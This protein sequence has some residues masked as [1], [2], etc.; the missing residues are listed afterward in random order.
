MRRYL[1]TITINGNNYDATP[2]ADSSSFSV[3]SP[4]CSQEKKS[5]NGTASVNIKG[6]ANPSFYRTFM[7][8]LLEAQQSKILGNCLV[9]IKD[10]VLN[11]IVH[12]GWLNNDELSI[13]SAFF[14]D[15]LN[16]A[17]RDKMRLLDTKIKINRIWENASRNQIVQDLLVAL[18]EQTGIT[19]SYLSTELSDSDIVGHYVVSEGKEKTYREVIDTLLFEAIGYVLWYDPDA[20][21]FRI[22]IIPT[23]YDPEQEYRVVTY[24]VENR[25]VTQSSVYDNDGILLTYPTIT[26]RPN[27]NVFNEG[28]NNQIDNE[29]N[30]KG[31]EI[32][33]GDYFPI[34]GDVKEIY[35]E[36]SVADRAYISGESRL[37]TEG[38]ELLYAKDVS[39][40]L[41]SNP[42]LSIADAIPSVNWYG[43]AEFY[44]DRARI[45]FRNNNTQKSNVTTFSLTGTAVYVSALN[46]I[47]VPS[48]CT[49]PEE[50][51]VETIT[52]NSKAKAFADWYYNSR[53]Y[54]C[55]TSRWSEP[56]GYS[57]LG[58]IVLV[59]H[60]D[61]GV[62]MPHVVV[63]ITDSC[64]GGKS[65][66]IRLKEIVA[67]S[68]YGWQSILS[69]TPPRV[70]TPSVQRVENAR[71][72]SGT[73]LIG[74][75]RVRGVAG[76]VGDYYLN[77]ETG[78]IYRCVES[79]TSQTAIWQW[80]MNNKGADA[81]ISG[82]KTQIEYG[83]STSPYS[84]VYPDGTLGYDS[85]NP[86]GAIDPDNDTEFDYG[87]KDVSGWTSDYDQWYRGLYVWMRVKTT[88]ADGNVT[89]N[90]PTYCAELT[91][92]LYDGSKFEIIPDSPTWDRNFADSGNTTVGFSFIGTGF[93]NNTVFAQSIKSVV[94]KAYRGSLLV[95]TYTL[96]YP[97]SLHIDYEFPTDSD[98]DRIDISATLEV[99][100]DEY[101]IQ[102]QYADCSMSAHDI[103]QYKVYGGVF[104]SE[105]LA[106]AWFNINCGGLIDGY[107][108]FDSTEKVVKV[109]RDGVWAVFDLIHDVNN[110]GQV[111]T[112]AERDLWNAYSTMTPEQ[113]DTAFLLYGYK[114][115]L[116]ARAIATAKLIMY[117]EG[118][119]VSENISTDPTEDIDD[120]FL[121]KNGYRFEG[122]QNGIV[123]ASGGYFNEGHFKGGTFKS[124]KVDGDSEFRGSVISDV[125]E[126]VLQTENATQCLASSPSSVSGQADGVLG[127]EIKTNLNA[128]L[129]NNLFDSHQQNDN[130]TNLDVWGVSN[131][132]LNGHSGASINK[133]LRFGSVSSALRP[134]NTQETAD[135]STDV[136]KSWTNPY[137]CNI[138]IRPNI[139][140][141]VRSYRIE[142]TTTS[143]TKTDDGSV[144]GAVVAPTQTP[145]PSNP[146]DGETWIDYST[147]TQRIVNGHIVYDY[148]WVE[149]TANITT[150][151]DYDDVTGT[152]A[153]YV[154]NVSQVSYSTLEIP[155]GG[156]LRV[157]FSA[158][159]LPWGAESWSG[160]E[161][162][163]LTVNWYENENFKVGILFINGAT[164][165]N[166]FYLGDLSADVWTTNSTLTLEGGVAFSIPLHDSSD[167]SETYQSQYGVIHKLFN[168]A[169]TT[170]A[171][172]TF[173]EFS[174]RTSA[175]YVDMNGVTH[176]AM[177]MT[178]LVGAEIT[179]TT[180]KTTSLRQG[181]Y[182]Y[183]T[184]SSTTYY[185]SFSVNFTP[186]ARTKGVKTEEI[187]PKTTDTYSL[188]TSVYRWENIYG[189]NIHYANLIQDSLRKLKE[190]I[191]RF[192]GSALALLNQTEIVTYNYKND[193]D[194]K[195]KIGF[196]AD[197]TP[198]ELAGE[199]HDRMELDHCVALLIKAVQELSAEIERLK[200]G[201]K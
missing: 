115:Q 104:A 131:V 198:S 142:T 183:L 22:R 17:S 113:K 153:V 155:S 114:E 118:I 63:Q 110:A 78:D 159:A 143:W 189:K 58:E 49:K 84:L 196:I 195:T 9:T 111:L 6:G 140:S 186:L 69:Q 26:E 52:D 50:Y 191:N 41:A 99:V 35:Q 71:W 168:F 141:Q 61:T 157:D 80:E 172:G 30:I 197:D 105:N 74:K 185:R 34:D 109:V 47:T 89:Y 106:N 28:I 188:G 2:I 132:N 150:S 37:Q 70:N 73:V 135:A 154:N 129:S 5:G 130:A 85:D 91:Q 152:V 165:A 11:K 48:V 38:L 120:G 95:N 200:G 121:T 21:G 88:D 65:G 64:A 29:G 86:Y 3:V 59:R 184:F 158:P 169:W 90:T 79:G 45:L 134:L 127:S 151:Y 36:Y 175:N 182:T 180:L 40:S 170:Y 112:Q 187:T 192:D 1:Y 16:L 163:K 82:I 178:T 46:R 66:T 12:R 171:V 107:S 101:V 119:I 44:P 54:G 7:G 149:F 126:T 75:P 92:S 164:R 32:E 51:K 108:F 31:T 57:T 144:Y 23:D 10:N 137:P 167:W 179:S 161:N 33:S 160:D 133:V 14:P 173:T 146:Y 25:L 166:S 27:T 147:P 156:V 136:S 81:D 96:N 13:S 193:K 60:K 128:W 55:T 190:N 138:K 139:K 43:Q 199:N 117:A 77:T 24:R 83:M 93:E 181:F 123:R 102:K 176:N 19:V 20:D 174:S 87:F 97:N 103:T 194:K 4:L 18:E 98:W 177:G 145:R 201:N 100:I 53:R 56:E 148:D 116:I 67:I 15:A 62:E 68:L 76:N 72:L 124:I 162:G 39:Y 8:V 122:G 94:F 42:Q 125:F